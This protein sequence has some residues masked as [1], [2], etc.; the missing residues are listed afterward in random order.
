M[1]LWNFV[2]RENIFSPMVIASV[3]S[4]IIICSAGWFG[5]R[6]HEYHAEHEQVVPYGHALQI[7]L[8]DML[9]QISHEMNVIDSFIEKEKPINI[10]EISHHLRHL[11][12]AYY[13][14]QQR[15]TTQRCW[16][17]SDGKLRVCDMEGILKEP[18][19]LQHVGIEKARETEAT[20]FFSK[21]SLGVISEQP[22]I[23]VTQSVRNP[24]G[25][26]LGFVHVGVN[27]NKLNQRLQAVIPDEGFYYSLVDHEGQLIASNDPWI[28]E[29]TGQTLT[30]IGHTTLM[31]K[32]NNRFDINQ[33]HY[34]LVLA[35]SQ[36]PFKIYVRHAS[37]QNGKMMY[38][39][40]ILGVTMLL[41]GSLV[42]VFYYYRRDSLKP[43]KILAR[44]LDLLAEGRV[45]SNKNL[46]TQSNQHVYEKIQNVQKFIKKLQ[47]DEENLEEAID[48]VAFEKDQ[49]LKANHAKSEFLANMSHELRTPLFTMKGYSEI[50]SN[51]IYG[52]LPKQYHPVI[53]NIHN[54][55][56]HLMQLI[57]D[58]LDLSKIEAGKME[59]DER[60][61][62]V[63]TS[64]ER[65]VQFMQ[66]MALQ[67]KV[68]I[69]MEGFD[70]D[71][72][73]LRADEMKFRQICLNIFSNAIKFTPEGG[74]VT[75]SVS[76]VEEGLML[77]FK[78]TGIGVK[79]ADISKVMTAFG[80]SREGE[81]YNRKLKQGTGLGLPMVKQ[82]VELHGGG[83][84]FDSVFGEGSTVTVTF[85]QA[86]FCD[87]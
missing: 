15:L 77:C 16:L 81:K 12:V 25:E 14:G 3:L 76:L 64:V 44:E 73:L 74:S 33:Q 10:E 26:L 28:A 84:T 87:P 53:E 37:S 29:K 19:L 50:I 9:H 32:K 68:N 4:I 13:S 48:N 70:K 8:T 69:A 85:P 18:P 38:W 80:Q 5:Y 59:L 22:I 55:G 78:D 27:V 39:G 52:P 51:E 2:R 60:K 66:Q 79:K 24:Q 41:F 45:L 56:E 63:S 20:P 31:G 61:I 6:V 35:T 36:S 46:V 7:S 30:F 40:G 17:S 58:I 42:A 71:L 23:P 1:A 75:V 86:R 62:C 57:N 34:H 82:L 67:N 21:R 47:E 72:P 11:H 54:A 43:L 83:L 49:A 65:C